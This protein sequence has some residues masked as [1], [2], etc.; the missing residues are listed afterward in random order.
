ML[1]MIEL[2]SGPMSS[3]ESDTAVW[4]P[5][6]FAKCRES[7]SQTIR[8]LETENDLSTSCS[9]M[10][11]AELYMGIITSGFSARFWEV[12]V[13]AAQRPSDISAEITR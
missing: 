9:Y 1:S 11:Q 13:V 3:A 2:H 10:A 12:S 5:Q 8:L 4:P 6:R 7:T